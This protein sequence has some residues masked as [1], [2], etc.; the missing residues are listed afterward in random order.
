MFS[1]GREDVNDE[2]RAGRPSTSIT[3]E[4]IDEVKTIVL[5]NRRIT[6]SEVAEDLKISI[7]S[8]Q[9]VPKLLNFDQNV[10]P[11]TTH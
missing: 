11:K 3:D 10:W 5:P 9:F 7:G 1:E 4:N 8:C 6:I 2:A